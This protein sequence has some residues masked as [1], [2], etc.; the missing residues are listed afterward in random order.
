MGSLERKAAGAERLSLADDLAHEGRFLDVAR[1]RWDAE[2]GQLRAE[3][4]HA[5]AYGLG[6][7]PK[8]VFPVYVPGLR[9]A[10]G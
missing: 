5:A 7:D 10:S 2:F 9:G 6:I 1:C 3:S 8:A 4:I